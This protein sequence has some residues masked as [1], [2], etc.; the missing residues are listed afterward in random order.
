M[1]HP[2]LPSLLG[3]FYTLNSKKLEN[4]IET[5]EPK[6]G[7]PTT[8]STRLG[9]PNKMAYFHHHSVQHRYIRPSAWYSALS[10]ANWL[11]FDPRVTNHSH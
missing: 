3:T 8:H 11:A 4:R 6:A 2:G 9:L 7:T 10:H 1:L 5:G